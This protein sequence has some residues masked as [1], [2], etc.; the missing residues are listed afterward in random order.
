MREWIPEFDQRNEITLY[1]N[2]SAPEDPHDNSA[3]PITKDSFS[4]MLTGGLEVVMCVNDV[5]R[6][7][8]ACTPSDKR[9]AG[10]FC[11]V[12]ELG[13][14]YD[15]RDADASPMGRWIVERLCA[16]CSE[17]AMSATRFLAFTND[18]LVFA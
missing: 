6:N 13:D 9:P 17:A 4:I 18:P 11:R 12:C 2:P 7:V 3:R 16:S 1:V 15:A 14:F 8:I 5:T 10:W